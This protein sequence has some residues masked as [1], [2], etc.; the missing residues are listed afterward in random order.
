[1]DPTYG[2]GCLKEKSSA[3]AGVDTQISQPS[4]CTDYAIPVPNLFGV[5]IWKY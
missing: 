4:H 1:M 5:S 2:L 3:R